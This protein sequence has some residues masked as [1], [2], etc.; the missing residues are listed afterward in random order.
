MQEAAAESHFE[1]T[2]HLVYRYLASVDWA[3]KYNGKR[4]NVTFVK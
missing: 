2:P 1:L 3:E 4:Y